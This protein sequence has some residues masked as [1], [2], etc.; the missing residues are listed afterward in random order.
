MKT[1][2]Q[3]MEQVSP[4]HYDKIPVTVDDAITNRIR[5]PDIIKRSNEKFKKGT[6]FNLPLAKKDY[7]GKI[8]SDV[9]KAYPELNPDNPRDYIKLKRLS[10]RLKKA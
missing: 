7:T 1:F 2:Q 8:N 4:K 5:T 10:T 6:G 9:L 3:F